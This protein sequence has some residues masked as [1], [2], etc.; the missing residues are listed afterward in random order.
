MAGGGV[1]EVDLLLAVLAGVE[2]RAGAVVSVGADVG[3]RAS[4]PAGRGVPAHVIVRLTEATAVAS[5]AD[6]LS[7]QLAV[8]TLRSCTREYR[9][10]NAKHRRSVDI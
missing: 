1:T 7:R 4:V 3:A 10:R 6:A 8:S 2:G 5:V 9:G